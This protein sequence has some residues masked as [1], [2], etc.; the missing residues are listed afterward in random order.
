LK[1]QIDDEF[2]EQKFSELKRVYEDGCVLLDT[3]EEL[4]VIPTNST[5]AYN[6]YDRL[7]ERINTELSKL[8]LSVTMLNDQGSSRSQ[9]EV[10][11]TVSDEIAEA[12]RTFIEFTINDL[13]LPRLRNL[14]YKIAEDIRFKFVLDTQ[15][16]LLERVSVYNLLL[17]H[18]KIDPSQIQKEFGVDVIEK[19]VP[20]SLGGAASNFQQ[21]FQN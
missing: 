17:N 10:H 14:G 5:D 15:A 13:L 12:D 2:K 11:K 9:S 8:I 4:Q 16:P 7:I 19:E 3:A 20:P 21:D 1:S 18:Y 6:I